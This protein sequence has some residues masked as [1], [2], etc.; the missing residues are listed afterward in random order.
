MFFRER[1]EYRSRKS[2]HDHSVLFLTTRLIVKNKY[3]HF[4][5]FFYEL[6]KYS[7]KLSPRF[8]IL[9]LVNKIT[10]KQT[11]TRIASIFPIFYLD[12]SVF[13][14]LFTLFH[15]LSFASFFSFFFIFLRARCFNIKR[16]VVLIFI[17]SEYIKLPRV[18]L[19]G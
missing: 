9:H 2:L 17:F 6:R 8:H 13:S 10:V 12:L 1:D 19:D 11:L 18:T 7:N 14:F 15:P 16:L 3:S 5:V 4:C